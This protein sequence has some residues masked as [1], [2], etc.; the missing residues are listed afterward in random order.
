MKQIRLGP[1]ASALKRRLFSQKQ[2]PV[3]QGVTGV[4]DLN[5]YGV[6]FDIDLAHGCRSSDDA[7]DAVARFP[8][9]ENRLPGTIPP[10][11]SGLGK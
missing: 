7:V 8:C 4:A 9:R 10:G 2:P 5:E 1:S 11:F 3:A 6:A